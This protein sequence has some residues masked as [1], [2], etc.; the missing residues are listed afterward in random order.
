ML[1]KKQY[2]MLN[3]EKI[4]CGQTSKGYWYCKELPADN[5]AELEIMIGQVNQIL[6]KY[7]IKEEPEQKNKKKHPYTPEK[8]QKN[9]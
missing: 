5:T 1:D 2:V 7:N 9:Q 8:K 4:V 6:N 3:E